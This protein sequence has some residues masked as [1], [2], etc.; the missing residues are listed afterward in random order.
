MFK[1]R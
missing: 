1:P